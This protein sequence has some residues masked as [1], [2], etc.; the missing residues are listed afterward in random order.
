LPNGTPCGVVNLGR[1]SIKGQRGR[2]SQLADRLSTLL[3]R[4][5]VDKTG[6][7]GIYNITA[8]WIPDPDLERQ[9]ADAKSASDPCGPSLFGALQQQLGLK[10]VPGK[11]PVEVMVVD[12]A[13]KAAAN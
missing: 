12:S 6:L 3:E 13:E 4:T 10:L 1:G 2:I 5:V 11:G 9:L 7:T 8:T